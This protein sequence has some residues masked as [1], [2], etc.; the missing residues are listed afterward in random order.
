MLCIY[1]RS[2][3]RFESSVN[4]EYSKTGYIM[5]V[6]KAV[7]ESS[8]NSEYSKTREACMY[9]KKLFESSVNSE[10]S[11]TVRDEQE[12]LPSLRVV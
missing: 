2:N 6:Q 3:L 12:V 8:V 9:N 10:Y 7:F 5:D 11:K 1:F 4:S